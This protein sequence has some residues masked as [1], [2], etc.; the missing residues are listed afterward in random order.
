MKR[1]HKDE[2]LIRQLKHIVKVGFGASGASFAASDLDTC[3]CS[4]LF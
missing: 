1:L 4:W 3:D 2:E